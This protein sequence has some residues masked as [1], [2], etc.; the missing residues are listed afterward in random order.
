MVDDQRY[1][2]VETKLADCLAYVVSLW[3]EIFSLSLGGGTML[4]R[5]GSHIVWMDLTV[6]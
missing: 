2:F 1:Q 6:P 3:C 4:D 5:V